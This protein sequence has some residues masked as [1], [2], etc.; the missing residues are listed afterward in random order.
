MRKLSNKVNEALIYSEVT[1][2]LKKFFGDKIKVEGKDRFGIKDLTLTYKISD[3]DKNK[4]DIIWAKEGNVK[5]ITYNKKT[6]DVIS[7]DDN[8]GLSEEERKTIM[9]FASCIIYS[10]NKNSKVGDDAIMDI[11]E[12]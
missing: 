11:I 4:L 9:Y 2:K 5:S 1:D 8:F 10:S 7:D 3:I 12:K 6:D